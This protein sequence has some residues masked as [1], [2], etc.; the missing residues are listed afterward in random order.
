MKLVKF[1]VILI[2]LFLLFTGTQA[3]AQGQKGKGKGKGKGQGG[4][5]NNSNQSQT[6]YDTKTVETFEAKISDIKV[7]DSQGGSYGVR[8]FVKKGTQTIEVRVGPAWFIEENGFD[9]DEDDKIKITGSRIKISENEVIIAS[10]IIKNGKNLKLR[11]SDGT[12][13]WK[14]NK[15]SRGK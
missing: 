12:P 8:L 2:A 10:V 5:N 11:E 3:F 15:S 9:F 1:L 13:L 4:Q 6:L 14:G 7:V